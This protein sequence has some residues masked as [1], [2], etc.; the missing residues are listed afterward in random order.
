MSFGRAPSSFE[1]DER[2]R[3]ALEGGTG[4]VLA[5]TLNSNC[6]GESEG[7]VGKEHAGGGD[8]AMGECCSSSLF[9]EDRARRDAAGG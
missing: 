5:A 8:G 9:S 3:E 2:G 4:E 7:S 1:E 6:A